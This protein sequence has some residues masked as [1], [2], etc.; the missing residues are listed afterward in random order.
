ML[1]L[2]KTLPRLIS[3]RICHGHHN[4]Q[5]L[6]AIIRKFHEDFTTPPP[7]VKTVPTAVADKY[8]VFRDRDSSVILDVEEERQ[9][10]TDQSVDDADDLAAVNGI[11]AGLNL[12]R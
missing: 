6:P 1:H 11:Y 12:E 2:K 7:V 4:P 3:R 10:L 8:R 5:Q 9:R